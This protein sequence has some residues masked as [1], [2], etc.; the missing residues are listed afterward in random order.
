MWREG[1]TKSTSQGFSCHLK[2]LHVGKEA[3]KEK[4]PAESFQVTIKELIMGA[5]RVCLLQGT[6]PGRTHGW[7]LLQTARS[8]LPFAGPA[9]HG[10]F[11]PYDTCWRNTVAGTLRELITSWHEWQRS[12]WGEVLYWT[13][14]SYKWGRTHWGC[15]CSRQRQLQWLWG[16]WVQDPERKEQ[17]KK[18]I[19]TLGFRRAD[20]PLQ[21]PAWKSSR[22]NGPGGKRGLGTLVDIPRSSPSGSWAI[23]PKK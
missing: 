23:H 12:Q 10:D 1:I 9:S 11:N 18:Q 5:I 20:W 19:T 16:G 8:S 13:S 4:K 15:E 3:F 22:G 21:G 7:G 17:R 2:H 14:Y 6:W